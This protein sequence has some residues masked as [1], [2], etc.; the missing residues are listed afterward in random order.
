MAAPPPPEVRINPTITADQL[1]DFYQRNDICG[2]GFG[3]DRAAVVLEHNSLIIAAFDGE[4][5]VGIARAMF[6]GLSAAIMEFSV[7][8]VLQGTGGTNG[9]GSLIEADASGVGKEMGQVL[10]DEL[11]Q[12]GA[13]F[14]STY[15][16]ADCEERFYESIGFQENRGH[17]IYHIDERPYVRRQ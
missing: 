5:L 15:I 6:D 14:I 11:R 12:M 4:Q 13:T 17:L 8:L 9:N 1:F 10:I 16:V 7:D 3:K 2:A